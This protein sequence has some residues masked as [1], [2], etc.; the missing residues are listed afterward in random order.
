[1]WDL[2]NDTSLKIEKPTTKN[3]YSFMSHV[4]G[5]WAKLLGEIIQK[6]VQTSPQTYISFPT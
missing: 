5:R 3:S 4:P 1:M 2:I 6:L